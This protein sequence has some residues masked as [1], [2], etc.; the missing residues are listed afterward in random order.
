M[1]PA[2]IED[3]IHRPNDRPSISGYCRERQQAHSF[4]ALRYLPRVG[5]S[6]RRMD[7]EQMGP[8]GRITP[9]EQFLKLS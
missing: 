6:L 9:I 2:T 5:A 3:P 7:A 4:K 8:R 1:E